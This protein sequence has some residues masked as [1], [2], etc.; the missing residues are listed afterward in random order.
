MCL[1]TTCQ[2]GVPDEQAT[3]RVH[4]LHPGRAGCRSFTAVMPTGDLLCPRWCIT[5]KLGKSDKRHGC[6]GRTWY[7]EIQPT[8]RP[9]PC[10]PQGPHASTPEPLNSEVRTPCAM[11]GQ[12]ACRAALRQL[13]SYRMLSVQAN[14]MSC[15]AHRGCC[16]PCSG[17]LMSGQPQKP[18]SPLQVAVPCAVQAAQRDPAQ[19]C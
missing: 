6:F 18:M 10:L 1:A 17:V 5:Y 19:G 13:P 12:N 15:L 14:A 3:Q 4:T 11:L 2:L 8:V 9:S 16:M 7:D